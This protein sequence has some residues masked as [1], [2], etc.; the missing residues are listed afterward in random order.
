MLYSTFQKTVRHRYPSLE[1]SF[2]SK[3][4]KQKPLSSDGS[5]Q[6]LMG[7]I[8]HEEI[9]KKKTLNKVSFRMSIL[10]VFV[11]KVCNF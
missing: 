3:Q 5:Q 7:V 11:S 8:I 9:K 4:N 2:N 1:K 10:Y 6:Y